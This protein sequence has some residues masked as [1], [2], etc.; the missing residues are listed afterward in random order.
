MAA[1]TLDIPE[2]QVLVVYNNDAFGFTHHHRVL[3]RRIAGAR[4]VALTPDMEFQVHDLEAE[5]H[6]ILERN[7]EFPPAVAPGVYAHDVVSRAALEAAKRRAA[8]MALILG[9]GGDPTIE[10]HVWVYA[11]PDH[12][13]FGERVPQA[14]LD[15]QHLSVTMTDKGIAARDGEEIL[16]RRLVLSSLEEWKKKTKGGAG[17]IRLLGDHRDSAGK[18]RLPL[19]VAV[20]ILRNTPFEDW[21]LPGPR[22][23]FEFI[24]SVVNGPGNLVSYH[25]EWERT[26]GVASSSAVCH[27]HKILC[28]VVRLAVEV[29]QVDGSNLMSMEQVV[30][31]IIQLETAVER[32]AR[33][34]DFSG[35][36]L[37]MAAPTTASGAART[38]KFNSWLTDRMKERALVWKQERLYR[39]ERRAGGG[40]VGND[41]SDEERPGRQK[42]KKK[43]KGRGRGAGAGAGAPAEGGTGL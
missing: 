25:A 39:E 7:A 18:R 36:D 22:A 9:D 14:T 37:V 10:E 6:V 24:S 23:F 16:I 19:S 11:E 2:A 1:R 26:S 28:D 20:A 17:D 42:K 3:V 31:R 12:V 33:V 38:D 13:S 43:Q 30:R 35:L 15:S 21:T 4:W 29:D 32:N 40:A 5:E 41:T 27:D 34:P 8:T